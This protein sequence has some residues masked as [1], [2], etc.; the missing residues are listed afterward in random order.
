M[1]RTVA[2]RTNPAMA[3]AI[4]VNAF[5]REMTTGMSAPPIGST[6]VTP[7]T[8]AARPVTSRAIQLAG[9]ATSQTIPAA[10][11]AASTALSTRMPGN[12]HGGARDDSLQLAGGDQRPGEGHPADGD[13]QPGGQRCRGVHAAAG[14]QVMHRQ[15]GSRA[16]AD[17]VEETDQL[18]DS[19]HPDGAGDVQADAT[20]DREA[21]GCDDPARGRH[22]VLDGEQDDGGDDRAGHGDHGHGVPAARGLRRV[23]QVQADDEAGR[24]GQEN[25]PDNGLRRGHDCLPEG[26]GGSGGCRAGIGEIGLALNI[27]SIRSVTA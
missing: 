20:A 21:G 4:P 26:D 19:G 25:Q 12:T 7:N 13:V 17:R 15:Q 14:G 11:A 8:S 3:T 23:H 1:I 9:S 16:A 5:S 22:G 27:S 24:G 10:N 2:S 18:R 6:M